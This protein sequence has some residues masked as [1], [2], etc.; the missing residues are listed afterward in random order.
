MDEL[1]IHEKVEIAAPAAAVWRVLTEP[2]LTKKYMFGCEALSDWKPGSALLWEGEYEGKKMVFVSGKVLQF[3][4]PR[5][6]RYTIFDPN[7][8]LPDLPEHH[9]EMRCTLTERGGVTLLELSQGD[10]NS[11]ADGKQRYEHSLQNSSA[12]LMGKM[13]ALAEGLARG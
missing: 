13:K 3:E 10:F 5:L 7:G 12:D 6:L 8:K 4:P 2:A 9:L 11:V 1:W